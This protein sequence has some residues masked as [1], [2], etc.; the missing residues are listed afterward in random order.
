L[1]ILLHCVA[2][3]PLF[4]SLMYDRLRKRMMYRR[5]ARMYDRKNI[6]PD[7][8]LRSKERLH[9]QNWRVPSHNCWFRGTICNLWEILIAHDLDCGRRH[10]HSC[11]NQSTQC[12]WVRNGVLKQRYGKTHTGRFYVRPARG[13]DLSDA[14]PPQSLRSSSAWYGSLSNYCQA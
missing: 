14:V 9:D 13:N 4:E 11:D 7:Y 5:T 10:S 8:A 3:Q 12:S 1:R 2:D 6:E